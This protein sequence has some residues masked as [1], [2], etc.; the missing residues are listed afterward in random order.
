MPVRDNSSFALQRLYEKWVIKHDWLLYEEALPLLLARDP[1]QHIE[2]AAYGRLKQ[3]LDKAV[4]EKTLP[5]RQGDRE[6]KV[7]MIVEPAGIYHWAKANGLSLPAEFSNLMEFVLKTTLASRLQETID[8]H[9]ATLPAG[10]IHSDIELVLGASFAVLAR[11]ND[12]CRG[13]NGVV[14]T[15]K[16]LALINKHHA[17]LFGGRELSLSSTAI[18]DVVNRWLLKLS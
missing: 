5:V 4:S 8:E 18:R 15:E 17:V 2:D 7:T 16:L 1:G 9:A 12:A 6:G 10:T 11:Y 14:K 3:A 13:K